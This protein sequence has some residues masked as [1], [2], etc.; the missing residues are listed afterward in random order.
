MSNSIL[1]PKI[2]PRSLLESMAMRYRHDFGFEADDT[3]PMPYG[4]TSAEKESLLRT[5]SQ[6]YEEATG[7]GFFK[8]KDC[9]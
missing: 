6:L 7:Q 8:F 2:P 3:S 9:L 4:M 1:V 5:M